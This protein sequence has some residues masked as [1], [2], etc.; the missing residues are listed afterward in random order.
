MQIQW[1]TRASIEAGWAT[2]SRFVG[3]LSGGTL[4]ESNIWTAELETYGG[5]IDRGLPLYWSDEAQRAR[6]PGD[7]GLEDMRAIA[8]GLVNIQ[9]P[10]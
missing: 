3:R 10:P 7:R 2:V 9:F 6:H 1:I 5:T 4:N 8:A